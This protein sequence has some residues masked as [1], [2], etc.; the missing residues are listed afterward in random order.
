MLNRFS[1]R[2][3][4]LEASQAVFEGL[5]EALFDRVNFISF[6]FSQLTSS[7]GTTSTTDY[8]TGSRLIDS[9]G[10]KFLS[11]RKM[12]RFRCNFYTVGGDKIDAYI[13]SPAVLDGFT[14]GTVTD[15]NA[16]MRSYVGVK[17]LNG[18]LYLAIKEVGE[19]ERLELIDGISFPSG[20]SDTHTLEIVYDVNTA[21]V[22]VDGELVSNFNIDFDVSSNDAYTYYPLFSPGRST[23]G[24]SVNL[25]VENLQYIQN[26]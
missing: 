5:S 22:L 2:E 8:T 3:E 23:D 1:S 26:R 12:S 24:T 19:D 14:L 20:A 6:P 4:K 7:G 10:G 25:V 21:R 16:K 18:Q 11:V 17:L 9:T 13:L 15:I